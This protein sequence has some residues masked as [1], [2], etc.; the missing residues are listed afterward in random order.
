MIP[1]SRRGPERGQWWLIA[2]T[3]GSVA[4]VATLLD[5]VLL[6]R[7]RSYFSGGFLSTDHLTSPAQAAAFV[8]SSMIADACVLGAVV[9][10]LR[11]IAGRL[12]LHRSA[13]AL[14]VTMPLAFV[15]LINVVEYQLLSY[16]GDTFDIALL[17]E[18]AGRSPAEFVAVASPQL[19]RLALLGVSAAVVVGALAW[20]A[21][22]RWRAPT[23]FYP[24]I[25]IS[26]R[27]AVALPLL[28]IMVGAASTGWIRT[29]SSVLDNGLRRKPTGQLLGNVVNAITDVDFDGF[30]VLGRPP[31]PDLFDARVQPYAL[32]VAGNGVDEDGVGGDLPLGLAPYA[33]AAL[34]G[35]RWASTPDVVLIV[36]ESFRADVLGAV[37]SGRP[38][39]PTLDALASGGVAVRHA[40]SH[41]GYTIQ[42]RRHIFSG[43][44]AD[45]DPKA[46]LLDDFRAQGYQTAYFSAQDES[47]GGLG[48][49][50]GFD[51]ADVF[52]DA[53]ADRDRRYSS[54]TTAGSLA[55]PLGVLG[56]RLAAF[57]DTRGSERPLF[58][59]VN[60][61]DTHFPYHHAG[62]EPL[63]SGTIVS[64][65]DIGPGRASAVREMYLNTAANVDRAI[66]DLLE[67]LRRMSGRD[68]A[69]IVLSDHGE[70]LFEEGF[71]GHGYAL[72]D[73]QTRIP[74]VVSN[75]PV[76]ID[77]P[78]GQADLRG[79]LHGALSA[80]TGPP[81]VQ[82]D[83]ERRVFQYLGIIERPAQIAFVTLEGR[84]IYD[85]RSR[86]AR[87]GGRAWMRETD[88]P[89]G[90][91]RQVVELIQ[92]WE[93]MLL[94]R[95]S[96][97]R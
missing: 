91:R 14:A 66:A 11:W 89:E 27:A 60:F 93:R 63:V 39:T 24:G 10:V 20:F 21:R 73:A 6:Q 25:V 7:R 5:A 95:A 4:A 47:F 29:R 43:S 52:Y 2:G 74:L 81:M 16:L 33:E 67:R 35:G 84:I 12:R 97:R 59:Y 78:F 8:A 49:G 19:T 88:L 94:T 15:V 44:V 92:T 45:L 51:R 68:P 96:A 69:V 72:D 53:R 41:N 1:H 82:P 13:A 26:G 34:P 54:F 31:D 90:E 62:I 30:G 75:L 32:E 71:L 28:L 50:V 77:E 83:R 22:R 86:R 70:S 3:I 37:L 18:L 38:V 56:S 40:Y 61:H 87:V 42:S 64:Q 85:V 17:F 23:A 80:G 58:L 46:S 76:T 65:A 36:L 57:L 48:A 9:I 55:V 79:L